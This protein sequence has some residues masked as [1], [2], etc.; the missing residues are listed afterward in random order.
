MFCYENGRVKIKNK[1]NKERTDKRN[2]SSGTLLSATTTCVKRTKIVFIFTKITKGSFVLQPETKLY[3][4][5]K[6]PKT[7]KIKPYL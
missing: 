3:L 4:Y 6:T 5:S 7:K 2:R 1:K